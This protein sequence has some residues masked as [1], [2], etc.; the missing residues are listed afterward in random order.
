MLYWVLRPWRQILNFRA[1]SPR[2]EYWLFI[3]QLYVVA[4][5]L[6]VA[7]ALTVDPT[8][9]AE[10]QSSHEGWI[11]AVILLFFIPYV[12]ASVRRLHDHDKGGWFLLLWFIPLVGWIFY[13]IMMLTPGT[14]GENGYG[15]D[16][17]E[18]LDEAARVADIFS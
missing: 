5:G 17:R 2:R 16:P 1:R 3:V 7:L 4:V 14:K 15:P 9:L 6:L 10:E 13:L 12:A 8:L 11:A 18:R